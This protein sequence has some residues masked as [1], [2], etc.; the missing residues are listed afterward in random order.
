MTWQ[1][2]KSKYGST[3]TEVDGVT[4]DSK[5]E[6]RRYTDLLL[7]NVA[8]KIGNLERQVSFK[9]Y[10][11][12][13]TLICTYRADFVYFEDNKR[14]AEDFKAIRTSEFKLK[15]KLFIDNYPGV[16]LRLTGDWLKIENK[17][18]AKSR[19]KY[20]QKKMLAMMGDKA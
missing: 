13:R 7:L 5:G 2:A 17:A 4:F 11:M 18:R 16:E 1:R 10:G 15:Q 9:L 6:A 12:G 8:G 20:A 19:A 14:V 3:R